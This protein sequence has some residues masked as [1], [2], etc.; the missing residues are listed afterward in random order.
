LLTCAES[1]Q[2]M[3]PFT[4]NLSQSLAKPDPGRVPPVGA[5]ER[6][7]GRRESPRLP[8]LGANCFILAIRSGLADLF[9]FWMFVGGDFQRVSVEISVHPHFTLGIIV[10]SSAIISTMN[11]AAFLPCPPMRPPHLPAPLPSVASDAPA[12]TS[13]AWRP[14]LYGV[15]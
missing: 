10:G 15:G 7:P 13:G 1:L 12:A 5:I 14:R 4:L 2:L 8:P 3:N 9:P 11:G 6:W